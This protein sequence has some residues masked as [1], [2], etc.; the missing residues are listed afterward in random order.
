MKLLNSEK[1]NMKI[2]KYE[3]LINAF[4]PSKIYIPLY[5]SSLGVKIGGKIKEGDVISSY[6]GVNIHSSIPG[7]L[8]EIKNVTMPS[9][10][11]EKTAV[12]NMQGAFSFE[13]KK[14]IKSEW[15][16]FQPTQILNLLELC[17]VHYTTR[18]PCCQ[19]NIEKEAHL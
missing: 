2:P 15:V 4:I 19:E 6:L 1:L 13:G 7:K 10:K 12:A 17:F 8:T 14:N 9:G 11:N 18:S 5:D 3:T 16:L